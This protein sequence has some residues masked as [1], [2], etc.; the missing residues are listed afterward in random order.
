MAYSSAVWIADELVVRDGVHQG[1]SQL[2]PVARNAIVQ[3][4]RL[5]SDLQLP[6]WGVFKNDQRT[7]SCI[8]VGVAHCSSEWAEV[9]GRRSILNN[10]LG[11]RTATTTRSYW[12]VRPCILGGGEFDQFVG[13]LARQIQYER[14]TSVDRSSVRFWAGNHPI[15]TTS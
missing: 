9:A 11:R 14:L 4:R 8:L 10:Q 13:V 6:L 12:V 3:S 15:L 1:I 7:D 2:W 5:R